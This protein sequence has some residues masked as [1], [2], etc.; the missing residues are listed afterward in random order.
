MLFIFRRFCSSLLC[1]Y[2][3][4]IMRLT[5]VRVCTKEAMEIQSC[6]IFQVFFAVAEI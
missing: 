5:L 3:S 4:K 2:Y 1:I 6:N